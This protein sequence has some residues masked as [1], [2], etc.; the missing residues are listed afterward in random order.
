MIEKLAIS[1]ADSVLNNASAGQREICIYGA[2]TAIRSIFSTAWLLAIGMLFGMTLN[3]AIIIAVFYI[4][5][6]VGGGKHARTGLGCITVMT[7]FMSSG[8]LILRFKPSLQICVAVGIISIFCLY[9]NPL[10]LHHNKAHL[11]PLTP[12][13]RS[14][15]H[16]ITSVMSVLF[17]LTVTLA[18]QYNCAFSIGLL[19]SAVSRSIAISESHLQFTH[20]RHF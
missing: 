13:L 9:I 19:F 7:A 18:K 14:R 5:Q 8:L 6:T 4:N 15:S 17:L 11:S 1:L 3:A 20:V 10:I 12:K 16:V 2:E